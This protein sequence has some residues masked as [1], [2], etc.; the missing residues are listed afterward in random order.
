MFYCAN[1]IPLICDEA[2]Y[3]G[4]N[5]CYRGYKGGGGRDGENEIDVDEMLE[6]FIN[7]LEDL[8]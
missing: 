2:A 4:I 7:E 5:Y 8:K 1:C 3:D 6:L